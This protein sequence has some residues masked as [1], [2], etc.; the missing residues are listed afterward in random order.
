MPPEEVALS[1]GKRLDSSHDPSILAVC[2]ELPRLLVL[3]VASP[4]SLPF[5]IAAALS[6]FVPTAARLSVW[7]VPCY[8]FDQR[9]NS[10]LLLIGDVSANP[11]TPERRPPDCGPMVDQL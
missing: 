2:F 5:S 10:C 6:V 7:G 3:F 4:Y 1:G 8:I 11:A 9:S